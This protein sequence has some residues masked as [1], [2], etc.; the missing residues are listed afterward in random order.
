MNR[1]LIKSQSAVLSL[2]KSQF[3]SHKLKEEST[4]VVSNEISSNMP[5][6][7]HSTEVHIVTQYVSLK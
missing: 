3:D 5:H 4:V 1:S 6:G 7:H 2:V